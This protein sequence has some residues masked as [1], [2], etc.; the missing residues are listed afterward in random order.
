M[1]SR[2]FSSIFP[3]FGVVF[4][5]NLAGEGEVEGEKVVTVL[6][7]WEGRI[8]ERERRGRES[9]VGEEVG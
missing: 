8:R 6:V 2:N 3:W 7:M 9:R 4:A 1:T 5:S